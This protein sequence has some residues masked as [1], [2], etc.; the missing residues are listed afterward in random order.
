M[1]ASAGPAVGK[2]EVVLPLAAAVGGFLPVADEDIET[3]QL[4]RSGF[5]H[6]DHSA[7][8]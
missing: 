8:I 4:I 5:G 3:G 2:S 7:L 6:D 1:L